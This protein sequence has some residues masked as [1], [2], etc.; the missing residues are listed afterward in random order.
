MSTN[1]LPRFDGKVALVTGASR[2]IGRSLAKAL[3]LQG[4]HVVA[5]AR[6]KGALEELDDEIRAEGGQISLL[7]LDLRDGSK[8]DPL[9]P[10]LYQR[11][12][13]LDIFAGNAGVLGPLSPLGHIS[14]AD[15]SLAMAVNVTANWRLIRTLDPLLRLAPAAR[16][17]FVT[18]G[19]AHRTR[20]YWG[21]YSVSKA[22]L[23]AL[24]TTYANEVA[25]TNIRVN[26]L[27]PG[28]IRTR[29]RAQAYPG[30]D[31]NTVPS[32]DSLV[33]LALSLLT[34]EVAANGERFEFDPAK[35]GG[36]QG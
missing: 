18:S 29:M 17:L 23:E 7:Q 26:L 2:G 36:R 21:P 25:S 13:R 15:W 16:V 35:S 9:G 28:R 32:P 6:T 19:A 33:P 11:W 10:T 3:A 27:D 1:A 14:E 20:A 12:G 5:L 30:E 8:I 4:A 22:A 34:E 31:V 24:A